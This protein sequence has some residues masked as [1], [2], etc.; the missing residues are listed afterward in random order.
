[1]PAAA[2]AISTWPAPGCGT[3]AVSISITSGPPGPEKRTCFI[4]CGKAI[5]VSVERHREAPSPQLVATT[6]GRFKGRA[7]R[8]PTAARAAA[9]G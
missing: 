5:I 3:G 8:T 6:R 2:T 7:A 9:R 1:M 4:V